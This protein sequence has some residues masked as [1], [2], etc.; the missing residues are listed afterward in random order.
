VLDLLAAARAV[1]AVDVGHVVPGAAVDAGVAAADG[2][3]EIVART[4]EQVVSASL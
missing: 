4:A 1:A 2:V 3:D